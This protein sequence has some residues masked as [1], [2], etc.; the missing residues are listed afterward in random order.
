MRL[1]VKTFAGIAAGASL[2][3]LLTMASAS[4]TPI[5][6][7]W[8][9]SAVGLGTPTDGLIGPA[10][11]FTAVD[12]A[13][14]T[15]GTSGFSEIGS[16]RVN[17]FLLGNALAPS[18]GLQTDYSLLFGFTGTG[19][20]IAI[21]GTNLANTAPFTSLNFTMYGLN[22][23]TPPISPNTNVATIPGVVPLAYGTL[24]NGTATLTNVNGLY[25]AKADLNLSL[26]ACAAAGQGN[27][28][29]GNELCTGNESA[30]FVSPSAMDISLLIGDFSATTSVTSI[31]G[32]TLTIDGG[33]GNLTLGATSLPE[34]GSLLVV[35]SGLLGLGLIRRRRRT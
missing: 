23:P 35:G 14:V 3:C 7:E 18:N 1:N 33:G 12:S 2:G 25:S 32:D 9:P 8:S 26:K 27:T 5:Q 6:F 24:E 22:G 13:T 15:L 31:S 20:P 4:A 21:P 10:D 29:F 28:G 17:D 11:N 19:Q 16:L 34:P 30:F